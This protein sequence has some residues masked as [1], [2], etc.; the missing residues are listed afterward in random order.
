MQNMNVESRICT[1]IQ[2]R[3]FICFS[4]V[5]LALI[6]AGCAASYDIAPREMVR[7]VDS[8]APDPFCPT[9]GVTVTLDH[10]G[11]VAIAIFDTTEEVVS[12]AVVGQ[13]DSGSY[14]VSLGMFSVGG[15]SLESGAYSYKVFVNGVKIETNKMILLK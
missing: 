11:F 2:G 4:L 5:A 7:R 12:S 15:E 3:G 14:F 8:S 10:A 13:L 6:A 9:P 1:P